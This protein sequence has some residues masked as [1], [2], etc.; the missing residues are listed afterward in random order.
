MIQFMK[1]NYGNRLGHNEQERQ[2]LE[3]LKSEVPRLKGLIR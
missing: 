1:D 2:E 3:F